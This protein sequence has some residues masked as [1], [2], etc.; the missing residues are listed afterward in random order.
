MLRKIYQKSYD[1]IIGARNRLC[2]LIDTPI[3]VLIYHRVTTL[4]SDP[5]QLAVSPTNFLAHMLFLRDNF[6]ILR[7]EDDWSNIKE[8]SV[9]ITFDDGYADNVRDAL[10]VLENV[11]VPAT[12]FVSTGWLGSNRE[13]W[14][15]ELERI[16]L[17]EGKFPSRFELCDES[18]G[19]EWTTK[20]HKDRIALY[21][22][23]HLMI[24][25][26][27]VVR[28]EDW[29]NQLHAWAGTAEEGRLTHR[30]MT[31]CELQKL[32]TSGLTTIGAHTVS[33]TPLATLS[34]H[35]QQLEIVES[36]KELEKL[37]G[38]EVKVFSYPFGGKSDYSNETVRLCRN[39]GFVRA[40]S[41]FPGH[42]HHWTDPYQTPRYL[43]RNWSL[44]IFKGKLKEYGFQ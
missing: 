20:C 36:K 32:A 22:E 43:V 3:I 33:H 35:E 6:P 2:N 40:A 10:P 31:I 21:Q 15:D 34:S 16:L 27:D 17:G 19:K 5:Q 8:P 18:L 14:W 44:E 39:A 12:F 28:R 24:K 9:V 7:F 26:I 23:I 1:G 13:F 30:A 37:T 42:V 38:R 41:N 25:K 11:G 29:F 4:S